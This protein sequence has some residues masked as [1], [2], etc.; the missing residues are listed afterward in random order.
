M[1]INFPSNPSIN[2]TYTFKG[3]T[4][5]WDG[6]KWINITSINLAGK[7]V[8]E[9]I[10]SNHN[11]NY[12]FWFGEAQEYL[13]IE[14][15]DDNTIYFTTFAPMEA[16]G[17]TITD[18]EIGG[19]NYRVHAF[20]NVGNEIFEVTSLGTN[21][22]VDVLVVAGGGAG[23]KGS[24]GNNSSGGGGA[25][26]LI[27]RND[28]NVFKG[29][30]SIKVGQGGLEF[31]RVLPSEEKPPESGNGENSQAFNLIAIGGGAG[32]PTDDD[33]RDGGS[34]GGEGGV[35]QS[36]TGLSL[37]TTSEHGGYGNDGGSGYGDSG[38]SVGGGG[39]GAGEKGQDAPSLR[40][41]GNGG[42]GLYYG[43]LFTNNFG[44]NGWFAGGGGGGR[45]QSGSY[46]VGGIGG[47][48]DGG[49]GNANPGL[50]NT[51]GGSGGGGTSRGSGA[52]GGSGIVLI[53]YKI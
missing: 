49:T 31:E 24:N 22:E 27:F 2:D 44:E 29:E 20:T 25:G 51:G 14:D 23:G 53:R 11:E 32:G 36:R 5:Q 18:I 42:E 16:T 45:N 39:G 7:F 47:G 1:A 19:E 12:K 15:K 6:T 13:N 43:D 33:A 3:K 34:G 40:E 41:A 17:G 8:G 35:G 52:D 9:V 4:Y 46:G 50:S 38:N 30:H 37:Q 10:D 21:N 26:G 28:F 48:G